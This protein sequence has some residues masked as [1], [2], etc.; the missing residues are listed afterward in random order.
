[1]NDMSTPEQTFP[2]LDQMSPAQVTD[3]YVQLRDAK[4]RYEDAHKADVRKLFSD[5]MDQIETRLLSFIQSSGLQSI[6]ASTGTAYAYE[7]T[8]VTIHDSREFQRH[9]I[10]S[11]AW[12]LVEWRVSKT[13]VNEIV[14]DGG[15][16]PPGVNRSP[17]IKLGVRRPA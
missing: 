3:R 12:D 13:A 7:A 10:G 16:L 4:K 1:M 5:E 2:W 17:I 8:S 14:E 9:V 6:S 11:E 15:V